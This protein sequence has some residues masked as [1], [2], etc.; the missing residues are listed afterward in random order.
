MKD[1]DAV[2]FRYGL[3]LNVL[4]SVDLEDTGTTKWILVLKSTAVSVTSSARRKRNVYQTR[5]T[6]AVTKVCP[7]L[8][9]RCAASATEELSTIGI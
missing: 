8:S 3:L 6:E 2:P 5:T 9:I 7:G 1:Q 4:V